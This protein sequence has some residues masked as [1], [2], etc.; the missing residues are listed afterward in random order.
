MIDHIKHVFVVYN[1]GYA[2]NFLIRLFS[3]DTAVVPQTT[4]ELI[5]TKKFFDLTVEERCDF[6]SFAGVRNKYLNWQKFHRSWIDFHHYERFETRLE[7]SQVYS[8][9][10]FGMHS[11]EYLRFQRQIESINNYQLLIV[12]LDENRYGNWISESQK[13]LNFKYRLDEKKI[14]RS[15][16]DQHH[17]Q[18]K[19]NLTAMLESTE[20]FVREYLRIAKMLNVTV[21]IDKAVKLYE[22]WYDTRV[23]HYL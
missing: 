12:D 14:Y 4:S 8:T 6:Y 20:S 22:E 19:I 17:D 16:L 23:R 10:I 13:D 1:P 7:D 18:S 15:L 9:I 3:L 11:P 5:D 2:G 21:H